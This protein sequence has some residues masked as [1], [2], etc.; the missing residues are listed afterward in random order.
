M[1]GTWREFYWPYSCGVTPYRAACT[2]PPPG[3]VFRARLLN[4]EGAS[5][6]RFLYVFGKLSARCFQRWRFVA[7]TSFQPWRSKH[8]KSAQGG[9]EVCYTTVLCN[10]RTTIRV[11]SCGAR[12]LF[13]AVLLYIMARD[14]WFK[15]HP[16]NTYPK[17]SVVEIAVGPTRREWC[18]DSNTTDSA[19]IISKY[20]GKVCVCLERPRYMVVVWKTVEYCKL[21]FSPTPVCAPAL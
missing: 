5:A 21:V 16:T 10:K 11:V 3:V 19:D 2:T 1:P 8:G 13:M 4:K 14:V 9:R 15:A 17:R 18:T 20:T 6:G 7:P 12:V